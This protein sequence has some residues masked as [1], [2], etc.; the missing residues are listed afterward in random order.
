LAK[1]G[2][3]QADTSGSYFAAV[4][5]VHE[6]LGFAS[7]CSGTA[8]SA[9][10][11]G[12]IRSQQVLVNGR[13]DS[14]K[15]LACPAAVA[16]GWYDEL[17]G[18]EAGSQFMV[19]L[20]FSVLSFRL[21]LRPASVLAIVDATVVQVGDTWVLRF[22]P[23]SYKTGVASVGTLPVL[24]LDLTHLPLLRAAL[25]L[26]LGHIR[27]K[28]LWG[29]GKHPTSQ[30][31]AWFAAVLAEFSPTLLGQLTAYSLRRGGASAARAAGVPLE[32]IEL[33]GG[34]A[35]GSKALRDSYLDMSIA[36]DAAAMFFFEGMI[37][38]VSAAPLFA[39]PFFAGRS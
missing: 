15:V 27:G 12:W 33:M 9:F 17:A 29:P 39:R 20:I 2:T 38:G 25:Q 3:V 7:P 16:L 14:A 13:E 10:K 36:A 34:W 32:V 21:F 8:F 18:L 5:T 19:P 22:K 35:K 28:S 24:S 23:E 30:G 6:I 11:K 37:P 31:A 26:H 1:K 4:N